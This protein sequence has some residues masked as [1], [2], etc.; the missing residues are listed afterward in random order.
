MFFSE[1]QVKC[2]LSSDKVLI[3][4]VENLRNLTHVGSLSCQG[5]PFSFIFY[6]TNP[7]NHDKLC[8]KNL[9]SFIMTSRGPESSASQSHF[10]SPEMR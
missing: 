9:S 8:E 7:R 6:F 5:P 2:S 10:D 1:E 4:N 3:K